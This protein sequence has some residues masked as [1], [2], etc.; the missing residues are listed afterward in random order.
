MKQK[1]VLKVGQHRSNSR[2]WLDNDKFLKSSGFYPSSIY[3][4]KYT[5]GI[6]TL[7]LSVKGRKVSKKKDNSII[8]LSSSKVTKSLE[9]FTHVEVC[10][11]S[12]H[13]IIIG[14]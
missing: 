9:G 7:R 5:S 12:Y 6:I 2:V 4:T 11:F 8:D 3:S 10:Y 14:V 1:Q 13:I